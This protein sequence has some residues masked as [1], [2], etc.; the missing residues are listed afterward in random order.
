MDKQDKKQRQEEANRLYV[1]QMMER[2]SGVF[3]IRNKNNGKV[4]LQ[5]SEDLTT[6]MNRLKN[7]LET[8]GIF[9][10]KV[11]QDDYNNL[12]K[13]AFEFEILEIIPRTEENMAYEMG[14]HF[15]AVQKNMARLSKKLLEKYMD[16][17]QPYGDNGYHRKKPKRGQSKTSQ[18][19][20]ASQQIND[21][22]IS[23]SACSLNKLSQLFWDASPEDMKKGY[24]KEQNMYVCLV[25][26][27]TFDEDIIYPHNDVMFTAKKAI[28][29]H[30]QQAHGSMFNVLLAMD[31]KYTGL[32]QVQSELIADFAKGLD[33]ES[34]AKNAGI[35]KSTV[36]N[37][38]FRLKEKQ[39][40]CKIF[41]AL[42]DLVDEHQNKE[43]AI[44][45]IHKTPRMLDERYAITRAH[46]KEV[47]EK[48]FDEQGHLKQLPK[49]E[50]DKIVVLFHF[51]SQLNYNVRYTEAQLN[52]SIQAIYEDF[53]TVRRY[54]IQY[55]F[56]DRTKDCKEYWLL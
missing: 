2:P 9:P 27:E 32:S 23:H 38:R 6:K 46:Q 25:C 26:G 31:K 3:L 35:A 45:S 54:L 40:Q 13:D 18:K 56:M 5:S 11:L 10:S 7:A 48:F 53:V 39:K 55:G 41:L 24:I 44:I 49:K 16:K 1:K 51:A 28:T 47:M 34:V 42:M 8:G 22:N 4:F 43:D 36:R 19:P 21:T 14:D 37:H 12:G 33:D 20:T 30:I 17:L 50:K 29:H 52:A 15:H